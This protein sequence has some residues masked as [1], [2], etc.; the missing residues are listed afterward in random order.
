MPIYQYHCQA[1]HHEI[2]VLLRGQDQHPTDCAQ[3]HQPGTL[4]QCVTAPHMRLKG[5]GYYETDE[6]PKN[7]QRYIASGD[8]VAKTKKV[9]EQKSACASEKS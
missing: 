4:R 9:K 8:A 6:K 3:C 2:E 5:G 1:C 7:K